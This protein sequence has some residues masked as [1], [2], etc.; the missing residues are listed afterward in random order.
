MVGEKVVHSVF[1]ESIIKEVKEGSKNY[2]KL[3]L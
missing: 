2:Q 1:G 3:L